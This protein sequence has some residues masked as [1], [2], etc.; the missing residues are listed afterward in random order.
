MDETTTS[1]DAVPVELVVG[2]STACL[3]FASLATIAVLWKIGAL[4]CTEDCC[5]KGSLKKWLAKWTGRAKHPSYSPIEDKAGSPANG[6]I[7][8]PSYADH[9]VPR[10]QSA[11]PMATAGKVP[12]FTIPQQADR[13]PPHPPIMPDVLRGGYLQPPAVHQQDVGIHQLLASPMA[14]AMM[15]V[16]PPSPQLQ[17]RSLS[18]T[19]LDV[20]GE[21]EEDHKISYNWSDNDE[22]MSA[23]PSTSAT[24]ATPKKFFLVGEDGH[25]ITTP[26]TSAS[27][28]RRRLSM[29]ERSPGSPQLSG[30]SP[31]LSQPA[32]Q[33]TSPDGRSA[34]YLGQLNIILQC[35]RDTGHA[36]LS[37]TVAQAVDLS[38][39]NGTQDNT[40]TCTVNP[41]VRGWIMPGHRDGFTT[42]HVMG[43]QS[44][45]FNQ[46]FVIDMLYESMCNRKAELVV[47]SYED[48]QRRKFL[49]QVNIDLSKLDLSKEQNIWL[50]LRPPKKEKSEIGELLFSVCYMRT[51][52]RLVF[53]ILRAQDLTRP[54]N[55][56]G[57]RSTYVKVELY[58][59]DNRKAKKKTK[60]CTTTADDPQ[61]E[62]HLY[63][64]LSRMLSNLPNISCT[65]K[66]MEKQTMHRNITV[67]K[68]SL[69]WEFG[70]TEL[71]HWSEVFCNAG[72]YVEQW[73][74]LT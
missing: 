33:V 39:P 61:W 27:T 31:R 42:Q 23:P 4:W 20:L 69:G 18:M 17:P 48:E 36:Q 62:E 1:P 71:Q 11:I 3:V 34:P 7:H 9:T 57:P 49:G 64:D 47:L 5:H 28:V 52:K 70:T 35:R 73:H 19:S 72:T 29:E 51:A 32:V 16:I 38:V 68:V 2:V 30:A 15:P 8:P 74:P 37:I 40:T 22:V 63:F 53:Q 26:D 10:R 65:V 24:P 43:T 45:V 56:K 25:I 44:P 41:Y 66:L 59:D 46:T 13:S 54:A 60:L 14:L 67:G 12:L 6:P 21:Q 55:L 50:Q 58:C